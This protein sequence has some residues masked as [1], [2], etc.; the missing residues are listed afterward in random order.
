MFWLTCTTPPNL[1]LGNRKNY[2]KPKFPIICQFFYLSKPKQINN[3]KC[4][5][6]IQQG[7]LSVHFDMTDVKKNQLYIFELYK[8]IFQEQL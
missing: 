5:Q 3:F 7:N 4:I 6:F 2:H 1:I 8:C